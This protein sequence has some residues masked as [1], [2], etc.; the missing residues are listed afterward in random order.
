M[1]IDQKRVCDVLGN[2]RGLV[3]VHIVDVVHEIN[4]PSLASV[5]RLHNPN[6][7]LAFML[8]QFLVMVVKVAKFVRQNV[9]VRAEVEGRLAEALLHAHHIEA[10]SV[11]TG[12]FITLWEVVDLLILIQ[13]LILVGFAR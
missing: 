11:F 2:V 5:S 10:E 7:L 13:A 3:N 4:T 9:R 12:N 1:T 8:L 6:I